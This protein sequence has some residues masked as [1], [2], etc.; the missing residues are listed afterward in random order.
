MQQLLAKGYTVHGTAREPTN[1]Q[2]VGHLLSLPGAAQRLRLFRADLLVQGSF[3]Q[4]M[5][6]CRCVIHTASP[7]ILT[8]RPGEVRWDWEL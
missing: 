3:L 1:A 4:A 2:A 8:V 5:Q 6:G 7:Y